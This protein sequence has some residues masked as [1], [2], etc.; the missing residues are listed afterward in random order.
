MAAQ[1]GH[2]IEP[3]FPSLVPLEVAEDWIGELQG[4]SLKNVRASL[5]VAGKKV[6]EEFGELLFTHFG[7]S[8]P[9]ILTLSRSVAKTLATGPA[10][11]ILIAVNLKPALANEVLDK[12]IQRDFTKFARKQLK[13]SLGELLPE[14]LIRL[15]IDLAFIDPD[16]PV[17]QITRS[18][19]VR[20]REQ[21]TG[22][23][24]TVTGTRPLAEAIITAGGVAVKEINPATMESKL[25]KNLYLAGEVIDIDGFT[26]GFNLQAAFST[27][28]AAGF[29]AAI[30]APD[31]P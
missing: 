16:K 5:L 28:Y 19:R 23:L 3:V 15:V 8:G 7:L 18:E 4:L 20:L 12:R 10:A 11:E 9:I 14:R 21:I 31:K 17:H 29:N 27:G 24:F 30:T 1:L 25:V 6:A 2:H 13:N 26:G 22:L